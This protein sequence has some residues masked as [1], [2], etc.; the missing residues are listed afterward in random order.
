MGT[1][2]NRYLYLN[3][4]LPE[5]GE[6]TAES[7]I[8]VLNNDINIQATGEI[9]NK[10]GKVNIDLEKLTLDKVNQG[11]ADPWEEK[12][13]VSGTA[14]RHQVTVT[15][16]RQEWDKIDDGEYYD[17]INKKVE[18]RYRYQ[19]RKVLVTKDQVMTDRKGEAEYNFTADPKSH[20]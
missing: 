19:E 7:S 1:V 8:F 20:T 6:I 3:A 15:V 11:K 4:A 14:G 2:R 5:S 17:F 13:F 18:K 12:A 9:T 10:T 16:F